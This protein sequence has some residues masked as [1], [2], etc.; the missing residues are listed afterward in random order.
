[1]SKPN[2]AR[3]RADLPG[4][5]LAY[6][7][8]FRTYATWLH[9]DTRGSVD[10]DHNVPDTA[11]LPPDPL[12]EAAERRLCRSGPVMLDADRR[13][14]VEATIIAV[15][16]HHDWSIH[17]L[18]VR[19]NHVH[20]VLSAPQRPE[21]IM[22]A[23]KSWCTRRLREANL[24]TDRTW[25]RHGSTQYLWNHDALEAACRYARD[26]QGADL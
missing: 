7:V 18:N 5:P 2:R 10:R 24:S 25:S 12:R 26:A 15:C 8:T 14:V 22:R 17:E 4:A 3:K 1:M 9:G 19:S 13:R 6:F 16:G 23:L 21:Q 20:V 11:F